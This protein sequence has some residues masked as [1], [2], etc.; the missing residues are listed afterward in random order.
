MRLICV[1]VL[2]TKV[3][4]S[5]IKNFTAMVLSLASPPVMSCRRGG[6]LAPL[7]LGLDWWKSISM[8]PMLICRLCGIT[9]AG[10]IVGMR[11]WG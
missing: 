10:R 1:T 2:I 9:T 8:M 3:L 4:T 7:K 5:V 11:E 6:V